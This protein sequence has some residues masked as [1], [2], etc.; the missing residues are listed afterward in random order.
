MDEVYLT[1]LLLLNFEIDFLSFVNANAATYMLVHMSSYTCELHL[2]YKFLKRT[3]F[4]I[5]L[6]ES[7]WILGI[8]PNRKKNKIALT[9][10]HQVVKKLF[11]A[12]I[13]QYNFNIA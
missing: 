10:G 7:K 8:S 12:L 4:L 2:L 1:G 3:C 6:G 9:F 5:N 11:G 13:A